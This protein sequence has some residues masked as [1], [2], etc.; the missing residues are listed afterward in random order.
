M[1]S[2]LNFPGNLA[3]RKRDCRYTDIS[4]R[5]LPHVLLLFTLSD[6]QTARQTIFSANRMRSPTFAAPGGSARALR[7]TRNKA[8]PAVVLTS[9]VLT[10]VGSQSRSED[11]YN[12]VCSIITKITMKTYNY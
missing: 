7:S 2:R 4:A 9:D 8:C 10:F 12:Y 11:N 3:K 6:E 1:N 5:P